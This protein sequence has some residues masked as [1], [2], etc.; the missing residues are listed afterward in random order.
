MTKSGDPDNDPSWLGLG[1]SVKSP[2]RIPKCD[3]KWKQG[4]KGGGG[5]GRSGGAGRERARQGIGGGMD[6]APSLVLQGVHWQRQGVALVQLS[7]RGAPSPSPPALPG[8]PACLP[9]CYGN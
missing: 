5:L 6:E 3:V 4:G 8:L 7:V 9:L 2:N 1:T